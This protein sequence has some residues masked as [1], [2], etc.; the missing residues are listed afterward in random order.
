V[1]AAGQTHVS[2]TIGTQPLIWS[3]APLTQLE[4]IPLLVILDKHFMNFKV[5]N[6]N[7]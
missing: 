2:R 4:E 6:F 7:I 3:T 5:I 1:V